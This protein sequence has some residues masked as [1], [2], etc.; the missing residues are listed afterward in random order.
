LHATLELIRRLGRGHRVQALSNEGASRIVERHWRNDIN[1]LDIPE[2]VA[3]GEESKI[4]SGL[5]IS[6]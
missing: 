4:S 3:L 6:A 1:L 2:V 5:Q